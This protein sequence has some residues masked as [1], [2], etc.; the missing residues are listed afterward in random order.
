MR[1]IAVRDAI[2]VGQ[3]AVRIRPQIETCQQI[4]QTVMGAICDLD[5][6]GLLIE[7]LDIAADDMMMRVS[8]SSGTNADDRLSLAS[9]GRV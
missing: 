9:L 1:E 3:A 4:E 6:Q 8:P 2:D 7:S 5:R